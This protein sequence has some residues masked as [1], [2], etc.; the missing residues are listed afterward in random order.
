MWVTS[1][2][3]CYPQAS[4]VIK[5]HFFGTVHFKNSAAW[6]VFCLLV[7]TQSISIKLILIKAGIN[8][9]PRSFLDVIHQSHFSCKLCF[10][11]FVISVWSLML[12]LCWII[13]VLPASTIP[14]V[15]THIRCIVQNTDHTL[16]LVVTLTYELACL[17][18]LFLY[19]LQLNF[20]MVLASI[21]S[22]LS[23]CEIHGSLLQR[24]DNI[25]W[26]MCSRWLTSFA[27][28]GNH[29]LQVAVRNKYLS[30]LSCY[31]LLLY[32]K[33]RL[34]WNPCSIVDRCVIVP[35]V[36]LVFMTTPHIILL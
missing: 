31:I 17:E 24:V 14:L 20:V 16:L 35:A 10:G 23:Q 12:C 18:S 29:K 27:E 22:D 33:P 9:T 28:N 2:S 8:Y 11:L 30:F 19:V 32:G 6:E 1:A 15:V 4:T 3:L 36:L 34:W 21:S 26:R 5:L 25:P 13:M 7:L